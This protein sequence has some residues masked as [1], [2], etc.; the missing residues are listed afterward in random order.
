MSDDRG[1]RTDG[2]RQRTDGRRQMTEA[3]EF[4]IGNAECGIE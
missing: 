3:L 1:Q 2:R 4:G